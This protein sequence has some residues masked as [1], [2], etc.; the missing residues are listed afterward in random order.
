VS[1]GHPETIRKLISDDQEE[2]EEAIYWLYSTLCHQGTVY[3]AKPYAVPFL[4][5]LA[6]NESTRNV[7]GFC[8]CWVVWQMDLPI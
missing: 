2:R 6:E 3:E 1:G 7:T 8:G 4:I 5:E